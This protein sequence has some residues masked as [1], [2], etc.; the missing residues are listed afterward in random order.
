MDRG[1]CMKIICDNNKILY[2]RRI[3]YHP[4]LFITLYSMSYLGINNTKNLYN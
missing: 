4:Y 2:K 3:R 1:I